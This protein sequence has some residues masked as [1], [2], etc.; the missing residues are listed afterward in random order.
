MVQGRG[1][2]LLCAA[3]VTWTFCSGQ[4]CRGMWEV[5]FSVGE[6]GFSVGRVGFYVGEWGFCTR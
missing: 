3:V 2:V 5:G 6:V 4:S 1:W